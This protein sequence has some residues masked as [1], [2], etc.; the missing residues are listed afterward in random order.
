MILN[1]TVEIDQHGAKLW[2]LNGRLH[3]IDGPAIEHSNGDTEWYLD[4][5]T[6]REDGPAVNYINHFKAWYKNGSVH[7][8]DGPAIINNDGSIEW[9]LNDYRYSKE[10]WFQRLTPEQQ[11][12]YFWNLVE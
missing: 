9:W 4:G 3:R 8:V 10:E 7:R 2:K 12:N 11:Y 5:K 1:I 6:H